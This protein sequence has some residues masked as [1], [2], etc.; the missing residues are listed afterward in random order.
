MAVLQD[1]EDN[2][3]LLLQDS[4]HTYYSDAQTDLGYN[5]NIQIEKER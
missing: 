1:F 3:A 2:I 4:V 5:I